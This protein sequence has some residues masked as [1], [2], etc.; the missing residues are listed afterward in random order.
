MATV[1]QKPELNQQEQLLYTVELFASS[2]QYLTDLQVKSGTPVKEIVETAYQKVKASGDLK[3]L[4]LFERKY[5]GMDDK[6]SYVNVITGTQRAEML[7]L[8][9]NPS[10]T[11]DEV[12][13]DYRKGENHLQLQVQRVISGG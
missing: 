5:K 12:S 13:K 9:E 7:P 3:K 10:M 6:A 1:L 4:R 8:L 2:L 11:V